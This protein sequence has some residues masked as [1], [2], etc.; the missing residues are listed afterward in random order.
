MNDYYEIERSLAVEPLFYRAPHPS[1]VTPY[2]FQLAGVEYALNRDH[3]LFG[4]APGLGKTA[5]CIM[6]SN[7][8]EADHT[9]VVCP[10]SLRL[11][12]EREIHQWSTIPGLTTSP[13]LKSRDG[14][15][16][17]A[18]YVIISYALLS[19]PSILNALMDLSW[20]HLILDEA[21]ALKDPKGN[22]RTRIIC[23]PET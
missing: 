10:A 2:E 19:N 8:I 7:A 14:V 11:N 12:W 9:L 13:I 23:A 1:G 16:P 5:E 4:D 18:H 3:M 21:H 20:D 6:L 15:S 22:N 17:V